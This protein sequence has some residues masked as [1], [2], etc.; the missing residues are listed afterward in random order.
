MITKEQ[1]LKDYRK[2]SE[3]EMK[4]YIQRVDKWNDETFPQL[5]AAADSWINVPVKEYNEGLILASAIK[6]AQP[7]IV[8][9]DNYSD[10]RVVLRK[11]NKALSEVQEK[12]G[13]SRLRT[14]PAG[15]K[16]KWFAA[17]Q[18]TSDPDEEGTVSIRTYVEPDVDGRRPQHV[19]EYI[20]LL[21][22]D[23]QEQARNLK[24]MHMEMA[25][26]VEQA[27]LLSSDPRAAK[28]QVAEMAKKAVAQEQK[29]RSLYNRIDV[30]Y[31][32]ATG[33]EVDEDELQETGVDNTPKMAMKR[34]G[35]YTKVEI[36]A[37]TDPEMQA[38]CRQARI[39]VNKKYVRRPM[40][41]TQE[42]RDQLTLRIRELMAW[43]ESI[44]KKAY[45]KCQ[46]AGIVI[47]GFNDDDEL[48][49]KRAEEALAEADD[50]L[51]DEDEGNEP[52]NDS[53]DKN[54]DKQKKDVQ[55]K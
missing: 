39:E 5:M 19:S 9:S 52:A 16:R 51:S 53:S 23:L 6:R 27:K 41:I 30:A 8:A 38:M 48:A 10:I 42:Y 11:I 2:M 1:F 31:K 21:P 46:E 25:D 3:T 55:T 44:P 24:A 32:V 4:S 45:Q 20:H 29:I 33:Q 26:Y 36:D 18:V 15:D 14:I 37:M 22:P 28:E 49:A 50:A 43:G 34:G 12:S 7:F 13:L 47:A 40:K 17:T 35:E 54:E